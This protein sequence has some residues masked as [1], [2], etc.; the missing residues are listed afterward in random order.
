MVMDKKILDFIYIDDQIDAVM[1]SASKGDVD[2]ED[3]QVSSSQESTVS[4]MVAELEKKGIAGVKAVYGDIRLSDVK[5]NFFDTITTKE[6][7]G[8]QPKLSQ[9]EGV[10]RILEYFLQ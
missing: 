10:K 8:W 7:P 1:L 6:Q 5:Q 3:F 9:E 4:E 2:G